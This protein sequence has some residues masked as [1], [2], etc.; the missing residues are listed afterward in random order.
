VNEQPDMKST[1]TNN[2]RH[3]LRLST[4]ILKSTLQ[5]YCLE[6]KKKNF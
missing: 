6:C 1:V 2:A 3:F 4:V 5:N